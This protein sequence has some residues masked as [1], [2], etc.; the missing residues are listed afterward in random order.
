MW[1]NIVF[2][3][4]VHT[5]D[6][7]TNKVSALG[8]RITRLMQIK[9][10]TKRLLWYLTCLK[11]G[12]WWYYM[13]DGICFRIPHCLSKRG[14]SI[15]LPLCECSAKTQSRRTWKAIYLKFIWWESVLGIGQNNKCFFFLQL[16]FLRFSAFPTNTLAIYPVCFWK[17][18][19]FAV[20]KAKFIKTCYLRNL[21]PHTAN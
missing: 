3:W 2:S 12:I 7:Y 15:Y 21:L 10:L 9:S 16:V 18:P 17:H 19:R 4:F 5:P 6:L 11:D 13:F 14:R 20:K 8:R 1:P